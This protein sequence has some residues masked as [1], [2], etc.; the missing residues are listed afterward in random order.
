MLGDDGPCGNNRLRKIPIRK[1]SIKARIFISTAL[2]L[3]CFVGWRHFTRPIPRPE[4]DFQSLLDSET[5]TM[6]GKAFAEA[7]KAST[8]NW[9]IFE[10]D[11]PNAF[12]WFRR[13]DECIDLLRRIVLETPV[14]FKMRLRNRYELDTGLY[15]EELESNDPLTLPFLPDIC[16][17]RARLLFRSGDYQK[18]SQELLLGLRVVQ[19]MHHQLWPM[20]RYEGVLSGIEL[21]HT[22]LEMWEKHPGSIKESDTDKLVDLMT[23]PSP[24]TLPQFY[25]WYVESIAQ[26]CFEP[27]KDGGRIVYSVLDEPLGVFGVDY[28]SIATHTVRRW[29]LRQWAPSYDI[30]QDEFRNGFQKPLK[31][32]RALLSSP[33]T[34]SRDEEV[35]RFIDKIDE[36]QRRFGFVMRGE[37]DRFG[38]LGD[39]E[40]FRLLHRI[41]SISYVRSL[42]LA[43]I[44]VKEGSENNWSGIRG[45]RDLPGWSGV[46]SEWRNDAIGVWRLE[47]KRTGEEVEIWASA[48]PEWIHSECEKGCERPVRVWPPRT[49][50][51]WGE[52]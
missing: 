47:L 38:L 33:S 40:R 29:I 31:E 28:S 27:Q 20:A 42:A 46:W 41:A 4:I 18:G 36:A 52:F 8:A 26:C 23:I 44:A 6:E 16:R 32:L 50:R 14:A 24:S 43:A 37:H 21:M 51:K 25:G 9:I 13:N 3:A 15:S 34:R 19:W 45:L 17:M 10:D 48:P 11:D 12:E 39:F 49:E 30:R 1:L 22:M 5:S 35:S 7:L 2:V